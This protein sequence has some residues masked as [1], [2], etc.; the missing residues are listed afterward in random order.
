MMAGDF[1]RRSVFLCDMQRIAL[2]PSN[3]P[4]LHFEQE[5]ELLEKNWRII[6][7]PSI[8]VLIESHC[9]EESTCCD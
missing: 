4:G 7:F 2:F 5:E 3:L 9:V 8:K 1:S 6:S